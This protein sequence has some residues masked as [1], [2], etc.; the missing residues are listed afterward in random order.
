MLLPPPPP[1]PPA[2]S[3]PPPPSPPLYRG[4][5]VSCQPYLQH[6][7]CCAWNGSHL[8]RLLSFGNKNIFIQYNKAI[9]Y[10][11]HVATRAAACMHASDGAGAGEAHCVLQPL[12]RVQERAVLAVRSPPPPAHS[13]SPR[14]HVAF[15][16]Q[17]PYPFLAHCCVANHSGR[18]LQDDVCYVS[19]LDLI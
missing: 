6:R 7:L 11:N 10:R 8:L 9:P 19:H 17:I 2:S 4:S 16:F 1:P 18:L 13:P 12:R 15:L 5:A 14:S 3:L